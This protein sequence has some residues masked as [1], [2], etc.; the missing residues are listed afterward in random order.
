MTAMTVG[1]WY[2]AQSDRVGGMDALK[3]TFTS[4]SPVVSVA[5]IV[6]SIVDFLV[7]RATSRFWWTDPLGCILRCLFACLQS[8]VMAMTKYAVIGHAFTGSGFSG[9]GKAAYSVLRRNVVGGY[10]NDRAG[11][12]VVFVVSK[13]LAILLGMAAWAWFDALAEQSTLHDILGILDSPILVALFFLAWLYLVQVPVLTII[14]I[15]R[16]QS[17]VTGLAVVIP[18]AAIF[19]ACLCSFIISFFAELVLDSMCTVFMAYAVQA[20]GG[21]KTADGG[22]GREDVRK[23]LHEDMVEALLP[24]ATVAPA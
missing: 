21:G 2:F 4:S 17:Y 22:D 3:T 14:L 13:V 16:F 24:T 5:S 19:V 18:V 12:S 23:Q 7:S 15:C 6:S 8:C 10:V 20:D 1:S 11:A 9:S